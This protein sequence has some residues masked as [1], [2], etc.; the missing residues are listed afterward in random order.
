L[1]Q[2]KQQAFKLFE[3]LSI[4]TDVNFEEYYNRLDQKIDE[5]MRELDV[6]NEQKWEVRYQETTGARAEQLQCKLKSGE[7]ASF[8]DFNKDFEELKS[9]YKVRIAR[10]IIDSQTNCVD[11]PLG[12]RYIKDISEHVIGLAVEKLCLGQ[13]RKLLVLK[14]ANE[15]QKQGLKV[16]L[17]QL[18]GEE[19]RLATRVEQLRKG[20]AAAE[21][22][23][24]SLK[25]A[26]QEKLRQSDAALM[27]KE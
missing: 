10:V 9:Q 5:K 2:I 11:G 1:S 12:E 8:E 26:Q 25:L 6:R 22:E 21:K 17:G 23:L 19:E 20:K 7:Y 16:N 15:A 18:E 27:S 24:E 14:Q 4:S 3:S 13:E